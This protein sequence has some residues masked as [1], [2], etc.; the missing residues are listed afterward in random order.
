MWPLAW[1]RWR[2][3]KRV[4]GSLLASCWDTP[5]AARSRPWVEQQL[6]VCDAEMSSLDVANGELLSL[7]WVVVNGGRISLDSA[8]HCLVAATG[9]VG[10]SAGIHQLRDCDL[11]RA[12]TEGEALERLL[13]AARGRLLVFHHAPLDLAYLDR[14]SLRHFGAPLLLPC[15][16]TLAMEKRYL[17]RSGQAEQNGGLNLTA[18]RRRY[19]LPDYPAHNAL[20]DALAT[21]E[22]LL[23][24]A[25]HRGSV[26]RD[27][28]SRPARLKDLR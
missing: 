4:S 26:D 6:L 5:L 14:A 2:Y 9:S 8:T 25:S 16:D 1:R 12:G 18:C 27:G 11:A 19:G 15:L 28:R 13:R 23:A 10:Q 24:I 17:E 21:A 20:M 7:G 22:L 3:R